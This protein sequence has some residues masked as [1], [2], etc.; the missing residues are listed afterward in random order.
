MR[1]QQGRDSRCRRP[2][3]GGG[4]GSSI[5]VLI[6]GGTW[7]GSSNVANTLISRFSYKVLNN[8][9]AISL[10]TSV[11]SRHTRASNEKK[12]LSLPV[13]TDVF[14]YSFFSSDHY[15][16]ELPFTGFSSLAVDSVLP[17]GSANSTRHPPTVAD[18]H[19]TPAIT[20]GL[21]PLLDISPKNRRQTFF[22]IYP[23][24][25]FWCIL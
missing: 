11:S 18:N 3:N 23:E 15:R 4:V 10:D 21:H 5:P 14:K 12:L 17:W 24:I 7:R 20:G 8:L 22:W 2:Q 9:S 1:K 16:L 13:R 6:K 25:V 19:D